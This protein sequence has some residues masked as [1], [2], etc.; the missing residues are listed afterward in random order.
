[1]TDFSPTSASRAVLVEVLQVL[2]AFRDDIVLVG[3]WVPDLLY[4]NLGHGG[5]LD[6]DL[7]S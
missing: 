3:G 5:S 1:M 2:G 4:P 7:T 6:V